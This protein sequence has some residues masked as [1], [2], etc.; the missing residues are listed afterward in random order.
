M[1]HQLHQVGLVDLLESDPR[2]TFVVAVD[3]GVAIPT[4]TPTSTPIDEPAA[5]TI[6]YSN[7]SLTSSPQLRDSLFSRKDEHHQRFWQW[8]VAPAPPS[9]SEAKTND[10]YLKKP[11]FWYL[12]VLWS[13]SVVRKLWVVV[14]A[15]DEL[16]AAARPSK[17]LQTAPVS[18]HELDEP[19]PAASLPGPEPS[20]SPL[21]APPTTKEAPSSAA[22]TETPQ[23]QAAPN[24]DLATLNSYLDQDQLAFLDVVNGVD[25]AAT[26]IGTQDAWPP[27]LRELFYQIMTDTLPVAVY[28][29]EDHVVIYN[30]AFS[31]LCGFHHPHF[32]GRHAPKPEPDAQEAVQSPLELFTR[33]NELTT[34]QDEATIFVRDSDGYL[35]ETHV[36]SSIMP[37][38]DSGARVAFM[39]SLQDVTES[40]LWERRMNMLFKLSDTLLE[41]QDV[42]SYW[43][44]VLE[45]LK[46]HGSPHDVPLAALYS[47]ECRH[48][49][50]SESTLL[51]PRSAA[52]TYRLEGALDVPAGH[53]LVPDTFDLSDSAGGLGP[54][55]KKAFD[56]REMVFLQ[57]SDGTLPAELMSGVESRGFGGQC[58]TAVICPIQPTKKNDPLGLL[59][60]GLNSQRPFDKSYKRYVSLMNKK[61]SAYLASA[62]LV[63]SS[64]AD[65]VTIANGRPSEQEDPIQLSPDRL[66]MPP[67]PTKLR[68]DL[69]KTPQDLPN[70]PVDMSRNSEVIATVP[71]SPL[72]PDSN[73][74][75]DSI[76]S[77]APEPEKLQRI[78]DL[79]TVGISETDL[80]GRLLVA[81]KTFF[82]LCG[83]PKVDDLELTDIRPW[84]VC[85]PE[86]GKPALQ[87]SLDRVIKDGMPQTVEMRLNT[88]CSTP[89]TLE[90][91]DK[92]PRWVLA[93]FMPLQSPDGN[94]HSIHGCFSDVSS[95]KWQ[96]ESERRRKEEALESKRQQEN[97]MDMTSHEMR[98]P[99]GAITHCADAIASALSVIQEKKTK[100][101]AE[102]TTARQQIPDPQPDESAETEDWRGESNRMIEEC[103]DN[104][105]TI[106]ACA[107]HQKR[108][109]DDL[110]TVSKLD[111]K[112]V[113]VTPCTV[114]PVVMVRNALKMFEV[115]AK[116]I[117]VDL[118][119]TVDES[120]TSMG[121]EYFDFDP[122]RAKQ[123]LINLLTNALKFTKNRPVRNVSVLIKASKTRPTDE[124]SCVRFMPPS[125]DEPENPQ[126]AL[127]GRKNPVYLT[128][129]VK[130]SGRGL[131]AE[132]MRHL[133][134]RFQQASSFTHVKHGGSGLGLFISRRLTELQNGAIGVSSAPKCGSTF[135]FFIEAYLPSEEA[136]KETALAVSPGAAA[137]MEMGRN[138]PA[139]ETLHRTPSKRASAPTFAS[140]AS[141]PRVPTSASGKL[142]GILVVE[143]NVINQQVAQRGLLHKG[144]RV[145][146]AN[147][148]LEALEKLQTSRLARESGDVAGPEK[149]PV[150][151]DL[152]LMDVEMPVQDG[153][154]CARK[155]RELE[156]SGTVFS[157]AGGRIPII[158]VS[159]HARREQVVSAL[160][161]GCDDVLVKPYRMV[162]LLEKIEAIAKGS[163]PKG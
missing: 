3:S 21:A 90:S 22:P 102:T 47:V 60:L 40:R 121:H 62:I 36:N 50:I 116:R 76:G 11:S 2:P 112:L 44:A 9:P 126:P 101:T 123:V 119:M 17:M 66:F 96:V 151:F 73:S 87:E 26:S 13:K 59:L 137:I 82:E 156:A 105:E 41:A 138:G 128:F 1:A 81:N 67:T 12:D 42:K 56:S 155:I 52:K 77:K 23:H 157:A 118:K 158:A 27:R 159:A 135:V 7:P 49:S 139:R 43:Q 71:P 53:P 160:E 100:A 31:K 141:E 32:L 16:P 91:Q 113:A 162:E 5:P 14:G 86:D 61:L 51:P 89:G 122:S 72:L 115:E 25:W 4:P 144:F 130:D 117:Q 75:H 93:T 45:G 127:V 106:I 80:N 142:D 149:R 124:T 70:G 146:V 148:G 99:L 108:I 134:N 30:H 133:F 161:A 24:N 163:G 39:H 55:F 83:I 120:F 20:A 97:F 143:D 85:V 58:T 140:R 65:D 10:D 74:M 95:Q 131:S 92:A 48:P 145:D 78:T 98:N 147:D 18:T 132:E 129:E 54:Q 33:R 34:V 68:L 29:G 109:I 88:F 104:A 69:S 111:S 154:T 46:S 35:T 38:F 110:L 8:I 114:D 6:A 37:I 15:N 136:V 84:D 63:E 153:L 28:W 94:I 19:S 64:V 107:Q 125:S 79:V 152:V 103:I 150:P 57:T